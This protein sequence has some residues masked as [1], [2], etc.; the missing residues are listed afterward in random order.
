M[1][2]ITKAAVALIGAGLIGSPSVTLSNPVANNTQQ[3]PVSSD[4]KA[5]PIVLQNKTV[6]STKISSGNKRKLILDKKVYDNQKKYRRMLRSN[7]SFR[8]SKKCKI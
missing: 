8:R 5:E 2:R 6:P 7:P 1:K 3:S 4:V